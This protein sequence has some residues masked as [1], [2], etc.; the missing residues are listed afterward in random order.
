MKKRGSLSPH[1][2]PQ[3][4]PQGYWVGELFL[5][6]TLPT[7]LALSIL[8]FP[9]AREKRIP[10]V[11]TSRALLTDV[12]RRLLPHPFQK[13]V[14]EEVFIS[15]CS[16][17]IPFLSHYSSLR[18]SSPHCLIRVFSRHSVVF[19]LLCW[20]QGHMRQGGARAPKEWLRSQALFHGC[21]DGTCWCSDGE[22]TNGRI[23][24]PRS[25]YPRFLPP[26]MKQDPN[27][28]G[29]A[30]PRQPQPSFGPDKSRLIV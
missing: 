1:G 21:H 19:V 15:P 11:D 28:H 20:F 30:V 12:H 27:S 5:Q 9:R 24:D 3:R 7:D 17:R 23:V 18:R 6:A 22:K 29:I 4:R 16:V 25:S 8:Q 13:W 2:D 14:C 26:S 10:Y